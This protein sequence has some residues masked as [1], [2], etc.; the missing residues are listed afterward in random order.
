MK[1]L[2]VEVGTFNQEFHT[3]YTYVIDGAEQRCYS[4]KSGVLDTLHCSILQKR[5]IIQSPGPFNDETLVEKTKHLWHNYLALLENGIGD[6][7]FNGLQNKGVRID[8]VPSDRCDPLY[9]VVSSYR[10]LVENRISD[11][12]NWFALKH[13]IRSLRLKYLLPTLIPS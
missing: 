5:D 2:G 10:I 9:K 8:I 12:Q 11:M 1:I 6:S 3:L 7:G 4:S 13:E